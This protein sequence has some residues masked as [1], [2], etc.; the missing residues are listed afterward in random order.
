MR[1]DLCRNRCHRAVM[2]SSTGSSDASPR[3][4]AG[5]GALVT[6]G[7]R[8]TGRAIARRLAADGATV[9][10]TYRTQPEAAESLVAEIAELN[11]R[12]Y[13]VRLDLAAP[14]EVTE[15]FAAADGA[16]REAGPAGWTFWWSTPGCSPVHPS[17]RP[18]S[19]TGS[20][21]WR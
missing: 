11:G 5:C 19:M 15:A 9:V 18:L 14:D 12:A 21:S 3:P 8:G 1:T 2:T 4:L 17:L 13:A 16:F 10:F 20:A 6:G 7:S